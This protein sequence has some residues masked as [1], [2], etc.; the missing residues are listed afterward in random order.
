VAA[1]ISGNSARLDQPRRDAGFS[2]HI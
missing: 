1:M 2:I